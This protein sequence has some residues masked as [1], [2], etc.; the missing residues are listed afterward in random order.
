MIAVMLVNLA[1]LVYAGS[2]L[3]LLREEIIFSSTILKKMKTGLFSSTSLGTNSKN[4][5]N[6]NHKNM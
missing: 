1:A 5:G 6:T 2:F 4:N 3:Y